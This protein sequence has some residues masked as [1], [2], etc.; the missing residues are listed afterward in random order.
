MIIFP[1]IPIGL[2]PTRLVHTDI[3]KYKI[4]IRFLAMFIAV[5]LK[6]RQTNTLCKGIQMYKELKKKTIWDVLDF[7]KKLEDFWWGYDQASTQVTYLHCVMRTFELYIVIL[8]VNLAKFFARWFIWNIF[9][10]HLGLGTT[11]LYQFT[12]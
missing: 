9:Y 6:L 8:T 12:S 7:N 11:T 10:I 3:L 1:I 5:S 4:D 2:V